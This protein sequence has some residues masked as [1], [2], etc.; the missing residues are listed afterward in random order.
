MIYEKFK[1][2]LKLNKNY[3]T[4][5]DLIYKFGFNKNDL[6]L[7]NDKKITDSDYV[8]LP[9]KSSGGRNLLFY[10]A[11]DFTYLFSDADRLIK[12]ANFDN[13]FNFNDS[14]IINGFIFSEIES[15][16]SIEGI[17]STRAQIERLARV[18]YDMVNDENE[19]I[20]KNMLEGYNFIRNNKITEE[21]IYKLYQI[22]SKNSLK[23]F[24][25]L[26][27]SEYYRHDEVNI[28]NE[29]GTIVDSGV[30]YKLLPSLMMDLIS[31]INNKK[32]FDEHLIASHIIHYYFVY[33]HPY[34]DYNGRMA[35]VLSFWYNYQ[36][37]PSISLLVT[38]EAIKSTKNSYY[39]A[40]V[41]SR[42][43]NNDLTY[44]LEYIAEIVLKFVKIYINFATILRE[45]KNEG[46]VLSRTQEIALKDILTISVSG[47]YFN[48]RDF[49]QVS[50]EKYTKQYYFKI[51]NSLVKDKVLTVKE[52]KNA[53]L[54]QLI[55][56]KWN[57]I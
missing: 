14:D 25:L 22:L 32:T 6:K 35:R 17:R 33:I 3:P 43:S 27:S 52:N 21:N 57:L 51:L 28:V 41:N 40:I 8:K 48:W 29:Y 11:S 24:E 45:L 37:A 26:Q 38:S 36:N 13:Q 55:F 56:K 39:N 12:N 50:S 30:D 16:L 44:F 23:D 20:I 4:D 7:I 18:D 47:R 2:L 10:Q 5:T 34:F 31:F 1:E 53:N 15:S 46:I 54:Y 49:S 42:R 19:L 9:L